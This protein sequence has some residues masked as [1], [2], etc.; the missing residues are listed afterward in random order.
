MKFKFLINHLLKI[1]SKDTDKTGQIIAELIA[2]AMSAINS[3][4]GRYRREIL[5]VNN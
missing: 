2:G 4:L 3:Q 5:T 1:L